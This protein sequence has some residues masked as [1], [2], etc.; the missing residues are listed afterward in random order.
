LAICFTGN[1]KKINTSKVKHRQTRRSGLQI[2]RKICFEAAIIILAS[3][4]ISLTVNSVRHDGLQLFRGDIKKFDTQKVKKISIKDAINLYNNRK[5][6]FVDARTEID[7]LNAHIPGAINLPEKEFDEFINDF[8]TKID[9]QTTI[10]TY[11]NGTDCPLAK[12]LS[13]KL[14]FVGYDNVYYLINGLNRWK[15]NR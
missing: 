5:A 14:V 9:S 1:I 13:E 2:M 12:N 4:A 15:E 6:L 3:V 8:L 10:I 11:C 7:F